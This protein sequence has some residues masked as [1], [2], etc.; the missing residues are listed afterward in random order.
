MKGKQIQDF[1]IDIILFYPDP[2]KFTEPPPKKK[3]HQKT[4]KTDFS[5]EIF[6]R[7]I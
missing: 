4:K 6:N 3:R 7:K 1:F 2:E 5:M